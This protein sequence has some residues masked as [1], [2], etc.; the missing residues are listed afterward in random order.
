[1]RT[2]ETTSS[3]HEFSL[4]RIH[5][6]TWDGIDLSSLLTLSHGQRDQCVLAVFC[7]S[8]RAMCL[9][10]CRDYAGEGSQG[11]LL[12]AIASGELKLTKS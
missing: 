12:D 10:F 11:E 5:A 2:R 3:S 4:S 8:D 7:G 9:S 1:M 6:K